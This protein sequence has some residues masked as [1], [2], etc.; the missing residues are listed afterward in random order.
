MNCEVARNRLLAVPDPAAVPSP[1]SAHV[2][3]CSAC[4]A[5]HQMLLRIEEGVVATAPVAA[6]DRV[7]RQLIAQFRQPAPE[8]VRPSPRNSAKLKTSKSVV[9]PVPTV[10]PGSTTVSVGERLARLWPAGIMAAALL[11]GVMVWASLSGKPDEM[12]V[13]ALPPD[14]FFEKVVSSKVKL[15]TAPDVAGRLAV[16]D[17]LER[18]IH[19][20]ATTLSKVTPGPEMESLARMYQRV[21]VEAMVEEARRLGPDEQKAKL[22]Q[23]R[24]RLVEAEQVANRSAAEAPPDAVRPLRDIAGAAEKGRTELARMMQ[25]GGAG[26]LPNAVTSVPASKGP[27]PGQR[28]E[29]YKKN[30]PVI[31]KLVSQTLESS[32]AP[33]DY[34]KRAQ[35]YHEVLFRFNTEIVEAADRR[36]TAHVEELTVHLVILLDQGLTPTLVRA[37]KQVADG[38]GNEEYV[39]VKEHL[40]A[41]VRALQGV[42]GENAG[43]R[44][45]LDA[46]RKKL[47]EITGPKKN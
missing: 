17:S 14:P 25:G 15:D 38:T 10:Q 39:Q 31:E 32:R 42:L 4:Q 5:W 6:S 26:I 29:L 3:A 35:T 28:G 45:S 33:N 22:G 2:T 12:T 19:D 18:T 1:V 20:E 7:K 47:D 46:A 9:K 40:H 41:Q 11:V 37:R 24:N 43:V 34:V 36:D 16:L 44:A 23:Y 13:A 30:R 27:T 8:G 21:V